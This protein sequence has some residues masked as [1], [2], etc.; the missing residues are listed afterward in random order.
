MA[1]TP[2][3]QAQ[4]LI[5]KTKSILIVLPRDPSID[6]V[7]S[8]LGFFLVLEKLKK[9]ARV[10]CNEFRLPPNAD[11]LPKS[12]DIHTELTSL[13]Q[14][15]VSLDVSRTSV[16]ELSYDIQDQKLNIYIT[17]RNGY[18][19]E[20]DVSV[21]LGDFAY[22]LIVVLGA[23]DLE[24]LGKLYDD[25]TEFFYRT[26]I[27]NIDHQAA[28]ENFGQVNLVDVTAT[29]VSEIVFELAK[30]LGES[31]L[32]EYIATNLLTG[33]ISK[34]KSFRSPVVTPK[35]LAIASH[36][37]DSGARREEIIK[38]LYQTKSIATLKLWGRTLARL[39]SAKNHA[40]IWSL[41]TSEDF[42]KS[43]AGPEDLTGAIDELIV[44]T[45][46]AKA[47]FVLYEKNPQQ[48][49][50]IVSTPPHFDDFKFFKEYH[51]EGTRGFTKIKLEKTDL[52]AAEETILNILKTHI[53]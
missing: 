36:L 49:R 7:A 50:G 27:L 44:N 35:S 40:I 37:I 32:D 23:A 30:Q 20:K 3:Q 14:F 9:E 24:L 26:P 15:I 16:E 29:S 19:E 13:R 33:I 11:F 5:K 53:Q 28:N 52:L 43:G 10:V 4:D 42:S 18:F 22:D 34:T 17:P 47:V 41:L 8:G 51:P 46:E 6:V 38:N 39:R 1:L 31:L 21:G 45:P 48:I 2:F 25:H 12:N